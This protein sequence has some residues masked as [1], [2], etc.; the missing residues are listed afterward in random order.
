MHPLTFAD[1]GLCG[2]TVLNANWVLTAAHCVLDQNDQPKNMANFKAYFGCDEIN[3]H[4][5]KGCKK[6]RNIQTVISHDSWTSQNNG[7]L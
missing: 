6:W 4:A 7:L 1:G 5:T 2:G 3:W